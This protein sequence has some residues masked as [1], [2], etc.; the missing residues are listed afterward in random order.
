M[1]QRHYFYVVLLYLFD[2][3][4]CL[5]RSAESWGEKLGETRDLGTWIAMDDTGNWG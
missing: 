1:G 3:F 2:D 4:I 5:E